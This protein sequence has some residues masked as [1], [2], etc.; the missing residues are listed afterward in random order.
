MG[1]VKVIAVV[2]AMLIESAVLLSAVVGVLF[3]EL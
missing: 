2:P 3:A 1:P